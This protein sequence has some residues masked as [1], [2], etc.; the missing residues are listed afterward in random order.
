MFLTSLIALSQADPS[1]C[2]RALTH[3][4]AA[5]KEA[6]IVDVPIGEQNDLGVTDIR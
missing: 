2:T 1:G 4:I 3:D 6:M 5:A